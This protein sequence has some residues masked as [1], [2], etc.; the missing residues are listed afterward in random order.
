LHEY[1]FYPAAHGEFHL[2]AGRPAEA[3]EYFAQAEVLARSRSEAEFF[4]RKLKSC[5]PGFAQLDVPG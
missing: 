2:L 4:A 3:R 1:P 5:Q